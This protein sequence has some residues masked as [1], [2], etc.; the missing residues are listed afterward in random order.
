VAGGAQPVVYVILAASIAFTIGCAELLREPPM[1]ASGRARAE[2]ERPIARWIRYLFGI[3]VAAAAVF[4]LGPLLL[5]G[6]FGVL[7]GA[8]GNDSFVYRQAG[9][10]TLGAAVGGVLVLR[11]GR[12]SATRLPAL[13]AVTFNGLSFIAAII[14]IVRGGPPIAFL[15]LAASAFTTVGMIVALYRRGR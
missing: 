15:I 8:S 5:G 9:A 10:A 12:W 4:A 13:M 14:E 1:T 11:S 2:L 7:L 6:Q 3:G